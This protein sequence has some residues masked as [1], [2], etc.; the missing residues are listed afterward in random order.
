MFASMGIYRLGALLLILVMIG[1]GLIIYWAY[2]NSLKDRGGNP[3]PSN[4]SR[5]RRNFLK[6]VFAAAVLAFIAEVV[7]PVVE[8]LRSGRRVAVGVGGAG[9]EET[10][11]VANV[12]EVPPDSQKPFIMNTNPDGTPGQHP[13]ILIH[14]PPDKA[15]EIGEEFVAFS[16]VCTHLGCIVHYEAGNDIFCPCHAGYFNPLT[17]E[18]ISGPPKRP[19]P[20]VKLR[21]D[22]NGDI[23]AE[24]WIVGEA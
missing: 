17:G 19:L 16:A 23:Y 18:A 24:G 11:K 8:M 9:G 5:S 22:E 21:I 2:I 14:L 4:V 3:S 15:A 7:S 20:K 13:A 10:R 12:E 6:G 1:I